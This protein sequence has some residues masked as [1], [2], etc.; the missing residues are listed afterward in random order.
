MMIGVPNIETL[1]E[2]NFFVSLYLV[3]MQRNFYNYFLQEI[4]IASL[5]LQLKSILRILNATDLLK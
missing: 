3:W 1:L 5:K 2:T 4:V